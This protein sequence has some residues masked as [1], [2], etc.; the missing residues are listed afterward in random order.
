MSGFRLFRVFGMRRAGNHAVIDWLRGSLPGES[1]F[2]NDCRPGD[3]WATFEMLETPTGERH[4]PSF[5]STRW[6]AQ[7]PRGRHAR[8]H[9]VSYEDITPDAVSAHAG[10]AGAWSTV[11]V[12]RSFLNWLASYLRL[13]LGRQ[14]GTRWG[15]SHAAE[16]PPAIAVYRDLLRSAGDAISFDRWVGDTGYRRTRLAS[17]G[18]APHDD[19]P[20]LQAGYG[21]GSS[22]APATLAPA[23]AN[24]TRRWREMA[25]DGD[26]VTLARHAAED[27]TLIE[28]LEEHYPDDARQLRRLAA[29]GRL[30]EDIAWSN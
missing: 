10:W 15:V 3:P 8:H 23:G 25:D 24:L 13:V 26:Y 29:T 7:F 4:G 16:I 11:I 20:T 22:F 28:T 17:L 21:G 30:T 5:R 12:H 6:F 14:R 1:V 19:R 18:L 9:I 2:L 27:H